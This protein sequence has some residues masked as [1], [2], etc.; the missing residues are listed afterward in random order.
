MLRGVGRLSSGDCE[1]GK[2]SLDNIQIEVDGQGNHTGE[3]RKLTRPV[4]VTSPPGDWPSHWSDYIDELD[5]H[6]IGVEAEDRS[7]EEIMRRVR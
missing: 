5:S 6:G 2:L 7:G 1:H 3:F 4:G